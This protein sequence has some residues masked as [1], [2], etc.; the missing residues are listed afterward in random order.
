[1]EGMKKEFGV[2]EVHWINNKL[3]VDSEELLVRI[4]HRGKLL[5]L[6]IKYQKSNIL[7]NLNEAQKGIASGQAVVFYSNEVCL[8]GGIIEE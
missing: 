4:R 8:G 1:M 6:N 3:I 7:V 5:K 2:R